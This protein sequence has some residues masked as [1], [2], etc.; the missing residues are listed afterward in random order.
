[1]LF[2]SRAEPMT[3]GFQ[4]RMQLSLVLASALLLSVWEPSARAQDNATDAP[5]RQIRLFYDAL[6]DTMKQAG[7]LGIQGRYDK[8]A[9]VIRATFDLAAMT[10]I[11]VGPGWNSIPPERQTELIESFAR[12]TIATYANRFDGYSGERF[13]VEPNSEARNSG[14][15]VRTKLIPLSGDAVSL[16]YLMRGSGETWKIVDVYLTGTI[17]ELATR[18]TEFIAILKN[19][20]PDA[21]IDSLRGQ[22]D[23]LMRPSPAKADSR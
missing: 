15:V 8:L 14:R 7:R 1:V 16:D 21:L 4:R 12:M 5:I 23:R 13:V 6:L 17:S 10:R 11:A 3:T 2:L 9:P 18:R 19:G 22:A 20:G